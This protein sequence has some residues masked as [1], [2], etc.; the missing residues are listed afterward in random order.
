MRKEH[1]SPLQGNL[2]TQ[3]QEGVR[4]FTAHGSKGL[5][6]HAVFIP[7]C[8]QDKNW[9]VKSRPILI[10]LPPEAFK[11]KERVNEKEQIKK[12]NLYDEIR[13]FYV[14]STRTKS[15]LF[16]TA[17]PT[18]NSVVSFY[19][20]ELGFTL[21]DHSA[22]EQDV[23]EASLLLTD[24]K[25]PFIGTENVLKDLVSG[26]SLNPT[27]INNYITCKRKFLYNNVLRIPSAKKRPLIFGTCVHKALEDAYRKFK[28]T[29]KFPIFL[30]FKKSFIQELNFQGVEKSIYTQCERE[31]DNLKPWFEIESKNPVMPLGLEERLLINLNDIAFKGYYDKTE[32]VDKNKKLIRVVDYKT[33][34]ADNHIRAI[35]KCKD[36]ASDECDGY[37]RQIVAYKLLFDKSVKI[38]KGYKVD[39][40]MLVFIDNAKNKNFKNIE[41]KISENMVTEL[42][43]VVRDCWKRIKK[44][45]FEKLPEADVKK[46]GTAKMPR[47]DYYDICW[48]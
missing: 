15:Q 44:L 48:G 39:S 38:N 11:T 29:K 27:S 12:L 30:F 3:T 32:I 43:D 9:P 1:R 8:L 46:C 24:K 5:E 35:G 16:Y 13:L 34:K 41:I 6:F 42:E 22:K 18:Q 26:L 14:A 28:E 45:E 20:E 33:G 21:E 47:C 25:D 37:L 31:I 23:I 4:V 19:I 36:L 40:G 17:S 7:F 10:P 2:V